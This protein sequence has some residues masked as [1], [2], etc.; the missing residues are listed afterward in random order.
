[1]LA[2]LNNVGLLHILEKNSRYQDSEFQN[3]L[4]FYQ[5]LTEEI[6]KGSNYQ[7]IVNLLISVG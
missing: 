1:M 5:T 2:E 3:Q 4:S 6:I 7:V